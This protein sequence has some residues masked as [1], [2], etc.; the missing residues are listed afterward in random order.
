MGQPT[1]KT[2][3]KNARGNASGSSNVIPNGVVQG[4]VPNSAG[5]EKHFMLALSQN[6]INAYNGNIVATGQGV[7]QTNADSHGRSNSS[8][9]NQ[10]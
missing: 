7:A 4:N 1:P 3:P 10:Q 2:V 5:Q 8:F 6:I 9:A